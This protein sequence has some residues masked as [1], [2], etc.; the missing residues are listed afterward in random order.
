M[1][2]YKRTRHLRVAICHQKNNGKWL[3]KLLESVWSLVD[4]ILIVDHNSDDGVTLPFLE[5]VSSQ[6][7]TKL[8]VERYTELEF[9]EQRIRKWTFDKSLDLFGIPDWVIFIDGDESISPELQR[10]LSIE[11]E[12]PVSQIF[13]SRLLTSWQ[14]LY[15]DEKV[16]IIN[17]RTGRIFKIFNLF[18]L[19]YVKGYQSLEEFKNLTWT[20]LLG[21]PDDYPF[22]IAQYPQELKTRKAGKKFVFYPIDHWGYF[23]EDEVQRKKFHH[24]VLLNNTHLDQK[25]LEDKPVVMPSLRGFN[26]NE[27]DLEKLSD[28]QGSVIGL[29]FRFYCKKSD[30]DPKGNNLFDF[31]SSLPDLDYS[32]DYVLWVGWDEAEAKKIFTKSCS[33]FNPENIHLFRLPVFPFLVDVTH[34]ELKKRINNKWVNS[35]NLKEVRYT[36]LIFPKDG[37]D[38]FKYLKEFGLDYMPENIICIENRT[39]LVRLK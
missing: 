4:K 33:K 21:K 32:K 15:G 17:R 24:E 30:L 22:H 1:V 5:S 16:Q 35:L 20:N 11:F 18:Y 27:L 3:P 2:R 29:R 34:S 39:T 23:D 26:Y 8:Y 10:F 13:Y 7:P 9:H 19:K 31:V 14:H 38:W 25:L 28:T 37:I 6:F 12:K 36:W